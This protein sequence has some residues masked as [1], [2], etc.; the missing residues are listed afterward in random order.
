MPDLRL[1]LLWRGRHH[2]ALRQRV[3]VRGIGGRVEI[4]NRR[5]AVAD[6]L[7]RVHA[8]VLLAKR[9]DLVKAYP[10]SL[11]ES[12]AAGKPALL[13]AAIPMA[14]FVQETRTGIVLPDVTCGHLIEAIGRSRE[15]YG[16]RSGQAAALPPT[17]F[18][19]DTMLGEYRRLYQRLGG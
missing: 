2:E 3:E 7:R 18:S 9:S 19:P 17:I 6:Y 10:H 14:D 12:L 1:I 5:V 4:V 8:T 13:S 15:N 16:A 11:L